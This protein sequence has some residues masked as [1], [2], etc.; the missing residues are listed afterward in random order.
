MKNCCN[1][2][3]L[4]VALVASAFAVAGVSQ[5]WAYAEKNLVDPHAGSWVPAVTVKLQ[6]GWWNTTSLVEAGFMP[7]DV[8]V[9]PCHTHLTD[10]PP[11]VHRSAAWPGE[12]HVQ[13]QDRAARP[14]GVA[15]AL[16]FVAGA[17]LS[18][19]LL[20]TDL[21]AALAMPLPLALQ[22]SY[23]TKLRAMGTLTCLSLIFSLGLY[24]ALLFGVHAK[25]QEK[26]GH[27][28]NV[29]PRPD[30]VS[31]QAASEFAHCY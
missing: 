27:S 13:L 24:L 22:L 11:A 4:A 3:L 29:W 31:V 26:F 12:C 23:T 6:I 10:S 9:L 21:A 1:Q 18:A 7:S 16:C 30:W 15:T 17:V 19:Y 2:L 28:V 20:L 25:I 14:L 5:G 8:E